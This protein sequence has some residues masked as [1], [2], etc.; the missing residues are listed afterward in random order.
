MASPFCLHHIVPIMWE[1]PKFDAMMHQLTNNKLVNNARVTLGSVMEHPIES[2]V[3]NTAAKM[4]DVDVDIDPDG[5]VASMKVSDR[6]WMS[7]MNEYVRIPEYSGILQL[8]LL[9]N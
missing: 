9:A 8:N 1:S 4:R 5:D 2:K 6:S 7:A 3:A